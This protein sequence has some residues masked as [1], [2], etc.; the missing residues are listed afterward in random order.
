MVG[1]TRQAHFLFSMPL[2]KQFP[3]VNNLSL[4]LIAWW[5]FF[6]NL[7][8]P[9]KLGHSIENYLMET[10]LYSMQ[11]QRLFFFLKIAAVILRQKMLFLAELTTMLKVTLK[12]MWVQLEQKILFTYEDE[13]RKKVCKKQ[14][15]C[16]FH[17]PQMY[18]AAIFYHF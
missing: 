10:L 11:I 5:I 18:C 13:Q 12:R 14:H 8:P 9:K 6:N 17:I 2:S 7:E 15:C 4:L 1:K 16:N 3:S